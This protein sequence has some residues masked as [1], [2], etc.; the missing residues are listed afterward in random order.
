M[1]RAMKSGIRGSRCP[2]IEGAGEISDAPSTPR[3]LDP[4][5]PSVRC[6]EV[7]VNLRPLQRPGEIDVPHLRLGVELVHFPPAFAVAVPCL[8]YPAEGQ[9]C[10]RSDGWSVD[11]RNSV[12]ELAQSAEGD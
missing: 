4:S 1:G 12:V 2:E 9:M 6:P 11:V 5:I 8:L 7:V 10:F 3:H